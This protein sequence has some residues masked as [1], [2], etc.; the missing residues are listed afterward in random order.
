MS[1]LRF[2][3]VPLLFIVSCSDQKNESAFKPSVDG[4]SLHPEDA[5]LPHSDKKPLEIYQER[6]ADINV[7][8][9]PD[10]L[11]LLYRFLNG[12]HS[13]LRSVELDLFVSGN[14]VD[15][16]AI[17]E[18]ILAILDKNEDR[19]ILYNLQNHRYTD[20]ATR[21]TEN[22]DLLFSKNMQTVDQN[23]F[24]TTRDGLSLFDCETLPCRPEKI[25]HT[26]FY[27][28]STALTDSNYY[29]L[30]IYTARNEAHHKESFK[31]H[32]IDGSGRVQSSFSPG[33]EI[34]NINV[35]QALTENSLIRYSPQYNL[36]ALA[37]SSFPYLYFYN[38]KGEYKYK[39]ELPGYQ[40]RFY[41]YN[42]KMNFGRFQE[43]DHTTLYKIEVI[44]S[45]WLLLTTRHSKQDPNTNSE[46]IR[47]DYSILHMGENKLYTI[48][49]DI[50]LLSDEERVIHITEFG[51][52]INQNGTLY[53][54]KL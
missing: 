13:Q 25:F 52:L 38:P 23:I 5:R 54:I 17:N 39:I 11:I 48:G 18:D 31:L 30:G 42:E 41:E 4:S 33:Y 27:M 45:H 43:S 34:P 46:Y 51:M 50:T 37:Y 53:W 40:Q 2:I 44:N 49:E 9:L 36:I 3:I 21:G 29:A 14:E 15:V 47:Y 32:K 16:S 35:R 10:N 26:D 20:I 22:G 7:T 6:F 24:I 19:L 28:Y 8:S 1:F 12:Y